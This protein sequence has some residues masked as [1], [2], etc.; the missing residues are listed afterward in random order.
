[1][2]SIILNIKNEN[3][4]VFNVTKFIKNFTKGYKETN[5]DNI[6]E[7]IANWTTFQSYLV[8]EVVKE[9]LKKGV[10]VED[11]EWKMH[12]KDLEE[13]KQIK[14]VSNGNKNK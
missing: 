7:D 2:E 9:L 4:F 11:Y 3:I 1:M 6:D 12:E 14:G 5:M 13:I 8:R 10:E